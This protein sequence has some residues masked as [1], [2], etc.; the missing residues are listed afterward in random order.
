MSESETCN[1]QNA[2][3]N[4]ATAQFPVY[5]IMTC[6]ISL[7]GLR[8][9]GLLILSRCARLWRVLFSR[10][11]CYFVSEELRPPHSGQGTLLPPGW[12]GSSRS[13]KLSS[14]KSNKTEKPAVFIVTFSIGV[15]SRSEKSRVVFEVQSA[16][17]GVIPTHHD[18]AVWTVW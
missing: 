16:W 2:I 15:K 4:K 1:S 13:T 6:V 17:L 3:N 18:R 14:V 10:C 12:G 8:Y 5:M 7:W 9:C 11:T